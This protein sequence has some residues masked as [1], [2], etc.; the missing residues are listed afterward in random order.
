MPLL[1]KT[2][3]ILK[4]L[5]TLPSNYLGAGAFLLALFLVTELDARSMR[6]RATWRSN[7]ATSMVIAW[8]QVSGS[9]PVLF[10]DI[11]DHGTSWNNY[12]YQQAPQRSVVYKSMNNQFARLEN[13][14]PNT[15]YYFVVKDSEGTSQRFSFRTAPSDPSTRISIIAGSDSRNHRAA[16]CDANKLVSK[17]RPHV[18]LFG[19]DMTEGDTD[20]QWKNWM[21]D[22]QLTI[23]SDRRLFPVLVARG[24][25]E[26]SNEVVVNL[27]DVPSPSVY[28]AL[29]LGG[30]LLRVY[31]LNTMIPGGGDQRDWLGR[32]L[33]SNRHCTWRMAQY[34]QSMRPHTAAKA[35][36][37][38][39]IYQWATLF[40]KF[41]VQMVVESDAHVVKSTWPIRPSKEP[42]SQEGFIRDNKNGTVYLGEGGWGAPL[43]QPNDQKAWTRATGSFNQ[44]KWIFV[45]QYQVQIRT[46]KTEGAD[47]VGEVRH[48]NIFEPP[49]G[50]VVWNPSTGDVVTIKNPNPP[51]PPAT[52]AQRPVT[53]Q[54]TTANSGGGI[55]P[56][57]ASPSVLGLD[58]SGNVFIDYQLATPANVEV[59]L[60]SSEMRELARLNYDNQAAGPYSKSLNLSNAPSGEYNLIVKA[61]GKLLVRYQVRI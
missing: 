48:S 46:V 18:V 54:N 60:I 55:P 27:F 57:T 47:R 59:I 56:N 35:E 29:T 33:E 52:I 5:A 61:N 50:L 44:F 2:K 19:G 40:H 37:E 28:Y 31:T 32:D 23:G 24:N 26:A 6:F 7:P 36:K 16:R 53:N 49:Y 12:R 8:D 10:Y 34:H 9:N 1:A 15:V 51:P 39:L 11:D 13:L 17:L 4:V 45:D 14:L 58:P 21:D 38:E 30:N 43:R 25:H 3:R 22:W 20:T 41:R 42:G